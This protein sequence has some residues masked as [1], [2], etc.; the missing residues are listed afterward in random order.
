MAPIG[1]N[2]S[3]R[4]NCTFISEYQ[5]F[6]LNT[7]LNIAATWVGGGYINGTAESVYD[8]SRGLVWT[9]APV[10]FAVSLSLGK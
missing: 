8:P 5:R 3:S 2:I 4:S 1:A 6:Q 9:Q 10:G 7:K